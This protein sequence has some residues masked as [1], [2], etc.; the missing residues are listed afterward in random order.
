MN[1]TTPNFVTVNENG[2]WV[3]AGVVQT[4]KVSGQTPYDKNTNCTKK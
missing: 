2:A 3:E 4:A 1:T